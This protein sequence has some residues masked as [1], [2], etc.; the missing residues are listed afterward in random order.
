MLPKLAKTIMKDVEDTL[1]TI[2]AR[3]KKAAVQRSDYEAVQKACVAALQNGAVL[4]TPQLR[5]R[6]IGLGLIDARMRR[7]SADGVIRN[8]MLRAMKARQVK[9]VKGGPGAPSRYVLLGGVTAK[10]AP[11]QPTASR[12]HGP[13]PGA[14]S[15]AI[16]S[17]LTDHPEGL[18]ARQITEIAISKKVQFSTGRPNNHVNWTLTSLRERGVVTSKGAGHERV[19]F[20]KRPAITVT[21]TTTP[22]QHSQQES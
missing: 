5:Q 11:A 21:K 22:Q 3:K 18:R 19:N 4:D 16:I 12:R 1:P 7:P 8:V 6:M 17:I 14:L 2:G 20:V 10:P 13:Q 9:I 15:Q